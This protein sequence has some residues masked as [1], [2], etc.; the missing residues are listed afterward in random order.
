MRTSGEPWMA[1]PMTVWAQAMHP[2]ASLLHCALSLTRPAAGICEEDYHG[3]YS[4]QACFVLELV[5][6]LFFTY[7]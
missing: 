1:G 7:A 3:I 5:I 2:W 4:G 6:F